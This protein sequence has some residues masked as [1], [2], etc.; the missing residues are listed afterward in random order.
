MLSLMIDRYCGHKI[1]SALDG[2]SGVPYWLYQQSRCVTHAFEADANILSA[3]GSPSLLEM[4]GAR[5]MEQL[6]KLRFHAR[7]AMWNYVTVTTDDQSSFFL[8]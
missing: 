3:S 2:V 7:I 8:N 4:T 6:V 5:K 1:L